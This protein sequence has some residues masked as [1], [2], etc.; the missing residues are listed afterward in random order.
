VRF[1]GRSREL[2]WLRWVLDRTTP[3]LVRVVGLTGAGKSALVQRAASDFAGAWLRCPPLPDP[4]QRAALARTLAPHLRDDVS[5]ESDWTTLLDRARRAASESS[6]PW[7]LVVDDAHRL[8]EARA[9][10]ATAAA[11][12]MRVAAEQSTPFHLVMVGRAA[13]MPGETAFGDRPPETLDVAPL[14]LRA[15]A[16][17][18]PGSDS[19]ARLRAYGVFGGIP[20]V[21]GALDTSVTVGTNVRRLLLSPD[22]RFADAP[23]AWLER[24]VQTPSRYMAILSALAHG[25]ADWAS[26][27]EGVQ[28]LTRSGQ[29][30]PYLKRLTELGL[31]TS[32]TPLDAGPRTRS[33]RY[34]LTDP[35]L[36][37]W[38]R[39]AFPWL[40]DSRRVDPETSVREH[41]ARE[42]RPL[43]DAHMETVMPMVARQHMELDAVETLGST[44]RESGSLWNGDLDIPVAGILTSG[45]A[46]YGTCGWSPPD[47]ADSPLDSLDRR[48]RDTRYGFGKERR[49]RIVF[50]GRQ[51]PTWLR[52]DAA[53]RQDAH[54]V[55]ADALIGD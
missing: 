9:R 2:G 12:V 53:R 43:I 3:Q 38:F 7:V 17:H 47:R 10:F 32:R 51:P 50:T 4:A 18:L 27:H 16:P 22:G 55:D 19:E 40:F 15:A 48:I 42:V 20:R 5:P 29:V 8:T 6:R 26:I 23:L 31:V 37:F 11:E 33:T 54:L 41:Y 24:E 52:R 21:L 13:G 39:F 25:E 14:P 30:A 35:F 34:A 44:A 49:L 28:D 1:T 46:Y 36:A 45:A